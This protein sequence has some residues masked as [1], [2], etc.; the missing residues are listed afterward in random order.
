MFR[1]AARV[2]P[3]MVLFVA[4][5]GAAPLA[6]AP[7]QP[8]V[9][10][11]PVAAVQP[12]PAGLTDRAELEHFIDGVIA[13]QQEAN[14]VEGVTVAVVA[15]GELFFAKGYGFAD[16]AAG[17]R[18]D[19]ERT[20]FRIG[21]VSKLFTWTA[22]MQLVEQ[23]R[24]DLKADVNTY[25][26]GSPVR[27]PATFARPVTMVDLLTHTPGFEDHVLG[28]FGR[29]PAAMRPLGD[30]LAAE[31]PARVR[32]PG[33]LSS[34]SNH[35]TAL[36]GYIVERI[37]GMPFERYVEER[38]LQ[39]LQMTHT[40][41]RQPVPNALKG[42]MSVGYRYADGEQ[43]AE[44]FEF[45]PASPAGAVSA[46]AVDM[47]HFMIAH[48]D[49][50]KY[51]D[52][53]ILGEATAREMRERL[54][55][56]VASLNGMLH[57]FYEMNR[58]GHRIYGHG[59]DTLWFH[60]QLALFPD[61]RV[62]LFVSYNNDTG[63]AARSAIVKA[64]VNRYFPGPEL[65]TPKT[66]APKAPAGKFAGSYRSIRMSYTSL[67]KIAALLQNVSVTELRDGRLLTSGLGGAPKRWV[68]VSPLVFRAA[69][70]DER[71][72]FL[73]DAGGRVTHLVVD[74]PAIAFERL[75]T[76]ETPGF[77]SALMGGSLLVL[78]LATLAWPAGA[79]RRRHTRIPGDPP[80]WGRLALWLA[81][82]ALLIFS[83]LLA[84]AV[85]DPMEIAF[86]VPPLLRAALALPIL[87]A[88]LT[89]LSLVFLVRT[90]VRRYWSLAGRIFY[91]LVAAF[92]VAFLAALSYWNLL[93]YR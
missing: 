9:V 60:S 68:G 15:N 48:L 18:V 41:V 86:G 56:H 75:G 36:A 17:R 51:G 79:W 24:L 63:S 39:P 54:F 33:Q 46:S 57:G 40:A 70:G 87:A 85:S 28:L 93:G 55:G 58:N 29:T 21:S 11:P 42:N 26:S 73:E 76:L 27:V 62:G 2:A 12:R 38:I 53:R 1:S 65:S 19:P 69:D 32:P 90:W 31:M 22:V 50:G 52:A 84:A 71:I 49:E 20:M 14:H 91:T 30:V 74:F 77:Q 67:T 80:R 10:T 37:S 5:A 45:V 78:F 16:R 61:A 64:F 83:A 43:K 66:P 6:Q 8:P 47:A 82:A 44:G 34:Y 89:L 35:G 4:F 72:A 13:A 25:L 7:G 88:G 23:G 92:A 81:G 3:W 59:G